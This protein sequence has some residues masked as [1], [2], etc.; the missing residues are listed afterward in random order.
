HYALPLSRRTRDWRRGLPNKEMNRKI[1]MGANIHFCLTEIPRLA[2]VMARMT[3]VSNEYSHRKARLLSTVYLPR[4]AIFMP[5]AMK[6]N[7]RTTLSSEAARA[8][9]LVASKGKGL[10]R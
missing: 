2:V 5:P 6:R 3:Q 1:S 10:K 9:T 4:F 8:K 7:S